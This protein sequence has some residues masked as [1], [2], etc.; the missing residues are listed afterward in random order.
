MRRNL[1]P[2]LL[3]AA[4]ALAAATVPYASTLGGYFLG[5]DFGL[6]Q[7]FAAKPPLHFLRHFWTSFTEGI[8]GVTTDELRPF[9]VLSYQ[10]G[11]LGG[12]T[13]PVLQHAINVALH[14][15]TTLLV[16]V[17][18][19]RMGGVSWTAAAFSGGVFA[20]LPA[21]V[22]TVVWITGRVDSILAL[23]YGATLL[24]Y[25]GWR[26]TGDRRLFATSL[27]L[28]VVTLYSKQ[29]AL[30]L[31][32]T[33][34]TFEWLFHP[35]ETRR[36]W[37]RVRP[38]LPHAALV[39]GMLALRFALFTSVVR[40][41]YLLSPSTPLRYLLME[42]RYIQTVLLGAVRVGPDAPLPLQVL[43][44]LIGLGAVGA[45]AAVLWRHTWSPLARAQRQYGA[46]LFFGPTWWLITTAPL[47]LAG[48]ETA[49]FLYVPAVGLAIAAGLTLDLLTARYQAASIGRRVTCAAAVVVLL[50]EV[51]AL[52]A[53]VGV[54][55]RAGVISATMAADVRREADA[56]PP[57]TLLIL[58][59]VVE[60]KA[61]DW[62]VPFVLQP[63]FAARDLASHFVVVCTKPAYY[64]EF[65]WFTDMQ[66]R[67]EAWRS[68]PV[69][70]VVAMV[71]NPATGILSRHTE[72]DR[73]GL[74]QR[75]RQLGD[76]RSE[77]ELKARLGRVLSE[78]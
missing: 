14:A 61:W 57:G 30:T 44:A 58:S 45:V 2:G 46:L 76:A 1:H 25:A 13:S 70:P 59:P 19:R 69:T 21:H 36:W 64:N 42:G 41:R 22:E 71:W 20:L 49:R 65:T 39:A 60:P 47:L 48:Y 53:G 75:V 54:W 29:S 10:L 68:A 3:A 8:W 12:V 55:N 32:A 5:D 15:A 52:R 33:L 4:L 72:E 26:Q 40:A 74:A 24:A 78:P 27:L 7:L 73:P 56:W 6:V 34:L 11:M 28:S 23:S 50:G 51:S 35:R 43:A 67:L 16:V 17:M 31:P 77:E 37:A 38:W 66:A 18:A 63:P 9:T 62:A